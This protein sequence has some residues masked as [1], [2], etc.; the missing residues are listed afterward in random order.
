[1]RACLT[2]YT[3]ASACVREACLRM[4]ASMDIFVL[5]ALVDELRQR[6]CGAV[7]AKVFQM[8][9]DDLLLRLW[10]HQDLRLLLSTQALWPRLHLTTARF[11]NPPHPPRFAAFLRAHLTQVR[12]CDITVRP[13]D[14]V[15][16]LC[17]ERPGE[18]G[19]ALRLIHE[20]HGQQANIILVDAHGIIL[21]ALKHMPAER[22][23]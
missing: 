21:E 16:S 8:S 14:R 4:R 22:A 10:R 3:S 1:M 19:A 12:L 23:P 11:R 20:L 17:W 15:V 6:L 2:C 9:P 18:P 13:Y 5:K 7:V